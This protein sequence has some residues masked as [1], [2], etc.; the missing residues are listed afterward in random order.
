MASASCSTDLGCGLFVHVPPPVLPAREQQAFRPRV[1]S[2]LRCVWGVS[3]LTEL[4]RTQPSLLSLAVAHPGRLPH[5]EL[6][7]AGTRHLALSVDLITERSE[8][9][10][11]KEVEL[12]GALM[13]VFLPVWTWGEIVPDSFTWCQH[14]VLWLRGKGRSLLCHVRAELTPR[15]LL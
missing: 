15:C 1:P 9:N 12:L 4:C 5:L 10:F 6:L 3:I 13:V 2:A 11:R 8:E 7:P 14:G